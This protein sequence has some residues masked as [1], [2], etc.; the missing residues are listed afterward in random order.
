VGFIAAYVAIIHAN[1][2]KWKKKPLLRLEIREGFGVQWNRKKQDRG[3]SV[4]PLFQSC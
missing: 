4:R 1:E 3:P 2:Q